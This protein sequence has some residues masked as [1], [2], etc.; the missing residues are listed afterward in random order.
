MTYP[1]AMNAPALPAAESRH[2]GVDLR[3]FSDLADCG[4]SW[5]RV[6]FALWRVWCAFRRLWPCGA[7]V[8][9]WRVPMAVLGRSIKRVRNLLS[10]PPGK[11]VKLRG[12]VRAAEGKIMQSHFE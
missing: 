1:A 10:R 9:P 12:E 11:E 4:D 5:R 3:R 6:S 8:R 2:S 7:V